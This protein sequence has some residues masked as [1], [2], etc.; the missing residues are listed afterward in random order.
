MVDRKVIIELMSPSDQWHPDHWKE[1][2]H[3]TDYMSH[4]LPTYTI[5]SM[6]VPHLIMH[7]SNNVAT[8]LDREP[9]QQIS[10]QRNET[11]DAP[12]I[13][14]PHQRYC[15]KWGRGTTTTQVMAWQVPQA[16]QPPPKTSSW[17]VGCL[18]NTNTQQLDQAPGASCSFP[19]SPLW[20]RHWGPWCCLQ[21]SASHATPLFRH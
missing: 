1:P 20:A 7:G 3:G 14:W 21:W 8:Q 12:T 5:I 10:E 17:L 18:W 9:S 15:Q 11:S 13:S 4:V 6:L 16:M 19:S 2:F